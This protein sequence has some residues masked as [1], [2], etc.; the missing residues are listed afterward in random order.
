MGTGGRRRGAGRP[1]WREKC[2]QHYGLDIRKLRNVAPET[3]G[4]YFWTCDGEPSGDIVYHILPGCI[5][6]IYTLTPPDRP[7]VD[8]RLEVPLE[9]TPCHFG[10]SR[11]WFRCPTCGR[12]CAII[13][14]M[15]HHGG[16]ACRLC[17]KLAYSSE[18]EDQLSRYHR[19]IRKLEAR[20]EPHYGKP[21]GMHWRTYVGIRD[22]LIETEV[23]L[24]AATLRLLA[25]IGLPNG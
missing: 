1:G 9:R 18:A 5:T 19:K 23:K 22:R 11:Q 15:T 8:M 17:M 6:L 25:C 2:E 12:R 21:L 10:G 14:G 3:S 20:L 13:Y 16:F 7:P 4:S 24:T